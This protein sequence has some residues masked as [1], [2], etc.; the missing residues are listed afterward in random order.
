VSNLF[1]RQ[2]AKA[3]AASGEV[4]LELLGN[5]VASAYE[6]SASD[7]RRTDRSIS[8]MIEELDQLNRSLEGVVAKR[9][10]ELREREQEL[11]AA[12]ENMPHGLIMFDAT[13]T[14]VVCNQRYIEMY[15]LSPEIIRPGCTLRELLDHRARNGTFSADPEQFVEGL[16]ASI[17]MGETTRLIVEIA[18]GRTVSL[19]NRRMS[20]GGWVATHEDITERRDAE[21]KIAHMAGH[22]MLTDLPNRVLLRERLSQALAGVHRGERLSVLYIDLDH[23][24][25]VND[26]L[27]HPIGDQLLRAVS[28]RLHKCVR[29]CDTV[30]RVGGD[31]FA[32]ILTAVDG[33]SDATALAC[34]VCDAIRAPYEIDGHTIIIDSSIGISLAP[35]DSVDPDTLMK[36]ADMALYR[37]KADGRGIYRFFEPEMDARMHARRMLELALRNALSKQEFE[38]YYQPIINLNDNTITSFEALIRWHHPERGMI[39]PAEFIPLSEEI[40]LIVPLGEWIV[41]KACFDAA[42][43][44]EDV[45]LAVNL[46]PVQ[47]TN[48]NLVSVVVNALAASG[49]TPNRLELEITEAVLMQNTEVT[50]ATLHRLRDLGVHISMDDFGTGYSSL[51]YLRSFPFDKIKIDRSF[52]KGLGDGKESAA[53]VRAVAGLAQSLHMTTTAEGVE[54]EQQMEHVRSLGCTEMQ[55]FLFS[56]P[57]C[58]HDVAR[59][60]DAQAKSKRDAA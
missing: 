17:A 20:S 31:E 59:M 43:W 57:I 6:Q 22:D 30:A 49:L 56:P 21:K 41:R 55:G 48:P 15:R 46:S 45:K 58:L 27:G 1:A 18:D 60:F 32:I 35:N 36:N 53:I 29:G 7:R 37:A 3:R 23:F 54:T 47:L 26:T 50:I 38:V 39:S 9:T 28:S 24:K 8:M 13:G 52:I 2:L 44:P 33:P 42:K 4:N 51:S 11:D 19:V 25:T 10:A 16:R 34:K 12:I 40:G 5:L 14:M